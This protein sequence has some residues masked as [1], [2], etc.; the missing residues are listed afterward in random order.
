[1]DINY[2]VVIRTLGTSGDMY[3]KLL[4]SIEKQTIQPKE[5]LIV[6]AE[7]YQPPTD[8]IKNERIIYVRKGMVNQRIEGFK[9]A[10]SK[11]LLVVDD[12]IA[13]EENFVDEL[14]KQ[15]KN[16][17][18]DCVTPNL[19]PQSHK[20]KNIIQLK[21]LILGIKRYS[22]K[23]SPYLLRIG[24]TGGTIA[25]KQ[26]SKDKIYKMQTANFQCFF[27]KRDVALS[28]HFE[29]EMWLEDTGYAW[30]D[31]QVFFYKA[32]LKGFNTVFASNAYYRHLDAKTGNHT[33]NRMYSNY[34]TQQR[35]ITI[36]WYKFLYTKAHKITEKQALCC[37]FVYRIIAQTTFFFLKCIVRKQM[38]LLPKVIKPYIDALIFI[39]KKV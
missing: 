16:S 36:F 31:D 21:Y 12:D 9:H 22:R 24:R 39:H 5:V 7:G 38:Q 35:N 8:H 26:V 15:I 27:I 14:Y 18:A 28:I 23:K 19:F 4:Q 6:M 17:H 3:K 20:N 10:I 37:A 1:M 33:T 29:E 2:S 25:C 32:Y 30:P 11:Y 34:Y 13:F